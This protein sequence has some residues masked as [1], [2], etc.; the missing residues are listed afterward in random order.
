MTMRPPLILASGSAIRASILKNH[1]VDFTIVKPGVDESLIKTEAAGTGADLQSIAIA[2][3]EAKCLAVAR[4]APGFVVGADQILEF[5]GKAFDKPRDME[6]ARARLSAMAGKTHS[7]INA[8]VLASDGE[9]IWRNLERPKLTVRTMTPAD[10]DRYFDAVGDDILTSVGAYQ[11]ET[12]EGAAL[13][14]R[15][16]GDW[17]AVQGLAVYPFLDELR[18]RGFFGEEW[19]APKPVLAS[20][21]GSPIS[22]SLS[23]LIHNEWARR[24]CIDGEYRAIEVA[25][26][27]DAFARAMNDLRAQG[28]AGVN[29]TIPHKENALRYADAASEVAKKIGAANMLTFEREGTL[30]DNSDAAGFLNTLEKNLAGNQK[31]DSAF[32]LGAGGAARGVIVALQNAGCD[33]ILIANRTWEKAERLAEEFALTVIDWKDRSAALKNCGLLVNSTS[34]GMTGEP[35]LEIDLT[36]LPAHAA[37]FDIVY[38]PLET[39]LLKAAQERG[40]TVINGLEMLMHQAVPGFQAWFGERPYSVMPQVD[41]DLREFLH[42]ALHK[43]G[44]A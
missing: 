35:P 24:C 9:I 7:L 27:Y 8:T 26:G 5:E 17:F 22:H 2:L 44:A 14:E 40:N 42:R 39:P 36:A 34:L 43:R 12:E 13:F 37:V 6:E 31:I 21:V 29:I 20:V 15:I 38:A 32:V 1:G 23:P 4:S 30:A 16:S 25:P 10:I 28:L 41:D 11:V 19:I 33:S 3:A 18:R